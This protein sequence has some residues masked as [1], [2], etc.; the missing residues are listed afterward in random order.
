MDPHQI[1]HVSSSSI[2]WIEQ[3]SRGFW[4]TDFVSV[5]AMGISFSGEWT[6]I[7]FNNVLAEGERVAWMVEH[8]LTLKSTNEHKLP[9]RCTLA[10]VHLMCI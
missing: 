7:N 8:G 5:E 4:M 10:M 2:L 1:G 3:S 9:A 6:Q